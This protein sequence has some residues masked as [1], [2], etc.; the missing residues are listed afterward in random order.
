M[1]PVMMESSGVAAVTGHPQ[2]LSILTSLVPASCSVSLIAVIFSTPPLLKSPLSLA[3]LYSKSHSGFLKGVLGRSLSAYVMNFFH[4]GAAQLIPSHVPLSAEPST[5]PAQTTVVIFGLYP[6]VQVSLGRIVPVFL[7]SRFDV[8][9]FAAT[10]FPGIV[11]LF[12]QVV[13]SG[14]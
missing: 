5:F 8:P 6:I 2:R 3:V 9:V 4:A 7:F 12:L 10:V 11:R 1:A 14:R 13:E